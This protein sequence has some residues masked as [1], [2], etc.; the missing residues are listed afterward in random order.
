MQTPYGEIPD[1]FVRDMAPQEMNDFLKKRYRRRSVLKGAA[2][3]GAGAVAGPVF[4]RRSAAF[5]ATPPVGPQWIAY[6]AD[7]TSQMYV[8][9]SAGTATG[10]NQAPPKPQVRWGLDNT[11]GSVRAADNVKQVPIPS[12]V[13]GEP[14]QNTFYN[15]VLLANLAPGTSYHYAVSNDGVTWGPDTTFTTGTAGLGDFR[16]TAFGD[17]AASATA[18]AMVQLAAA[19]NPAFHLIPGDLAYATPEGISIPDVTGY[20]PAQWDKYLGVIGPN[21]AQSIPWQS[22][23]GAHETEPL[24]DNGYAGF[25]TRFPQAYD[26]TSGSPVVHAF[27]YGNVAF[28]NLDGNDLSAQEPINNGYS[29]GVQTAW[30][31][32]KLAAYRADTGIDFIVVVCNCCAYST[33]Q[34]HGS[35][36]GLRDAWGPLFDQYQVDLVI[37]GHVHAYERT[38]PM[39]AKQ[40]TRQVAIGGT[41]NAAVDGT[42]YICAGGGGNGL[43]ATWYGTAD[44]GDAGSSTAPK[45]WQFDSGDTPAGGTGSNEDITDAVTG[46]SANRRGV[47]SCLVIDVTAPT[48][49]DDQT[50]MV[51]RTLMPTQTTSAVTSISN[52]TVIDSVTLVRTSQAVAPA[53]A[54]PETSHAALLG[55]VGAVALA[56]GAVVA[57][58]HR[59]DPT[60]D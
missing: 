23:V 38:N 31:G 4:W 8:S 33:N 49:T 2:A 55:V 59:G 32:Q 44:A 11:Y 45:V 24:D 14:I 9:W 56:G 48:A 52:P 35:D 20:N 10:T 40:V 5:G 53:P 34:N 57:S 29:N 39:R 7:P 3:L 37:S 16:F 50:K 22:S 28:I 36:G 27:T 17:E 19:Q 1:R 15:N 30:L 25:V 54:L 6:G 41:S 43:Y 46:Y 12:G 18:A 51:V 58:R 42:T 47:W 26:P 60:T 21:G 13:A